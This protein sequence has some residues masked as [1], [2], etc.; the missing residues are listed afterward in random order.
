MAVWLWLWVQGATASVHWDVRTNVVSPVAKRLM[1][2]EATISFRCGADTETR[3][4]NL[5]AGVL[6]VTCSAD[7]SQRDYWHG[8]VSASV[9]KRTAKL[10]QHYGV[11]DLVWVMAAERD[12]AID[13][14]IDYV[15]YE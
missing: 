6:R 5:W 10:A 9:G 13:L 1:P 14:T 12:G 3:E 15:V 11:W 2:R 8:V 4:F 7:R